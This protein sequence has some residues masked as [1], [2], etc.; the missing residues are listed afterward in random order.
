MENK[1]NIL[2]FPVFHGMGRDDAK[3]NWFTC[4]AIWSMNRII[5]KANNIT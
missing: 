1:D 2:R 5:D 3:Q 4:E